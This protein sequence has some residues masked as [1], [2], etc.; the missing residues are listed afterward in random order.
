MIERMS[1]LLRL[2]MAILA[3]IHQLVIVS[4]QD[5]AGTEE[6]GCQSVY[7]WTDFIGSLGGR[8]YAGVSRVG[9]IS[10]LDC[11]I[12]DNEYLEGSPIAVLRGSM[13]DDM[14][15]NRATGNVAYTFYDNE[16]D[17]V[18]H[19]GISTQPEAIRTS[20]G[21]YGI[22]VGGTGTWEEYQGF[23]YIKSETREYE[24]PSIMNYTLC[25]I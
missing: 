17:L 14:A 23:V 6:S 25:R 1:R 24:S 13:V 8:E 11:P 5:D 16:D 22:A 15:A 10:S 7:G 9:E 4:A 2:L 18:V 12:Y 3:I 19:F 21:N 20:D